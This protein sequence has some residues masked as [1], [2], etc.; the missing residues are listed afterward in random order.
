MPTILLLMQGH[1]YALGGLQVYHL[2][3][4]IYIHVFPE[5]SHKLKIFGQPTLLAGSWI[6]IYR[7]FLIAY[8]SM[9]GRGLFYLFL[10]WLSIKICGVCSICKVCHIAQFAHAVGR[11]L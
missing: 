3:F 9:S 1:L 11:H 7:L 2:V 6:E 5:L 10:Q 8:I 4:L